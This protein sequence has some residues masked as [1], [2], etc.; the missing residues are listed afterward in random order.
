MDDVE[1]ALGEDRPLYL[2]DQATRCHAARGKRH[3]H[4][5]DQLRVGQLTAREVDATDNSSSSLS[6]S[7]RTSPRGLVQRPPTD[8]D[9]QARLLGDRDQLLGTD[10]AVAGTAPAK[11]PL[12]LDDTAAPDVVGGIEELEL[13]TE[14]LKGASG[15]SASRSKRSSVSIC[16]DDS[17]RRMV[18]LATRRLRREDRGIRLV[19]RAPP[20]FVAEVFALDG[21]C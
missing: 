7:K 3:P 15:R 9:E 21:R 17:K 13:E 6:A 18:Q 8:L 1:G 14:A 12:R 2:E 11:Q 20:A 5:V 4:I 10:E 19:E 16:I